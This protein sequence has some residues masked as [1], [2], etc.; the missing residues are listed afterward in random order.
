VWNDRV[1]SEYGIGKT[2]EGSAHL[3]SQCFLEGT[4][5][6]PQKNLPTGWLGV[7]TEI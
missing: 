1:V 6:N 5:E 7:L 4:D 3:R 2:V